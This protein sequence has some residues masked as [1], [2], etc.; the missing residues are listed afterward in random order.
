MSLR[1]VSQPSLDVAPIDRLPVEI[2]ALIFKILCE[3]E[4]TGYQDAVRILSVSR[5]WLQIATNIPALWTHVDC[6][7]DDPPD[8]IT[9]FWDT[10]ALRVK[11]LPVTIV[12]NKVGTS[13]S[14][15]R[16]CRF[17]KFQTIEKVTLF[18]VSED[19]FHHLNSRQFHSPVAPFH[20][21]ELIVEGSAVPLQW[22]AILLIGFPPVRFLELCGFEYPTINQPSFPHLSKLGIDMTKPEMPFLSFFPNLSYLDIEVYNSRE[23]SPQVVL[24]NLRT[25]KAGR[26]NTWITALSCPIL[27]SFMAYKI[28]PQFR[29][30]LHWLRLHNTIRCIQV[31]HLDAPRELADAVPQLLQLSFDWPKENARH[32]ITALGSLCNLTELEVHD[33]EDLLT[34]THLEKVLTVLKGD[35]EDSSGAANGAVSLRK[36]TIYSHVGSERSWRSC[37]LVDRARWKSVIQERDEV[38]IDENNCIVICECD[39]WS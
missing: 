5:R 2:M 18:I 21:L 17:E 32:L 39:V 34:K 24:P 29:S 15:I 14:G 8:S 25:L 3:P 28:P 19:A 31:K 9:E 20:H 10:M 16:A 13:Q 37:M 30:V 12:I 27:H 4:F 1:M 33:P 11:N 6:K 36:L 38:C 23:E 35:G 7:L 26:V 22:D